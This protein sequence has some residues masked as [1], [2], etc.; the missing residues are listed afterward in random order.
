MF[1]V[2]MSLKIHSCCYFGSFCTTVHSMLRYI[3][4]N[5]I[6]Q[7]EAISNKSFR[8]HRASLEA[9][10]VGHNILHVRAAMT[11]TVA[12]EETESRILK[13]KYQRCTIFNGIFLSAH[14]GTTWPDA[15]QFILSIHTINSTIFI[16]NIYN[17]FRTVL[18]FF[19][20]S[21][22]SACTNAK[23]KIVFEMQEKNQNPTLQRP[24]IFAH[25]FSSL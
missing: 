24:D 15:C 1:R 17:K 4:L 10:Q 8:V 13:K 9:T 19:Q 3:I 11:A 16:T 22:S 2:Q 20:C 6:R 25:W 7:R 5:N 18:N 23:T 14:E 21:S 12:G